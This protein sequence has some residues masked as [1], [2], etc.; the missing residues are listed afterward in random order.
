M[1]ESALVAAARLMKLFS[2]AI[3]PTTSATPSC[4]DYQVNNPPIL[5]LLAASQHIATL[6]R[7]KAPAGV[8]TSKNATCLPSQK[9]RF[10]CVENA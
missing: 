4:S 5:A 7:E 9:A 8:L 10:A 1:V 2:G 3:C 6:A